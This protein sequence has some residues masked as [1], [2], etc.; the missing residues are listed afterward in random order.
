MGHGHPILKSPVTKAKPLVGPLFWESF[1]LD[2]ITSDFEC[3]EDWNMNGILLGQLLVCML[4]WRPFQLVEGKA[5]G[6]SE[7]NKQS[8]HSKASPIYAFLDLETK[9]ITNEIISSGMI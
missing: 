3:N 1:D 8:D 6:V 2:K 7:Q 9:I 4:Y 5:D